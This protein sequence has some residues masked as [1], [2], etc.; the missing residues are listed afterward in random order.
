LRRRR[1]LRP[2]PR[3]PTRPPPWER[4]HRRNTPPEM[5]IAAAAAAE[6]RA[7]RFTPVPTRRRRRTLRPPPDSRRNPQPP[8]PSP[9]RRFPMLAP[10]AP[11]CIRGGRLTLL[12]SICSARP[13]HRRPST[14]PD[15][16]TP[17]PK[18]TAPP[19]R[20]LASAP[21]VYPSART[22]AVAAV[23]GRP[24]PAP[25]PLAPASRGRARDHPPTLLLLPS[26]DCSTP[27]K[28]PWPAPLDRRAPGEGQ[29]RRRPSHGGRPATGEAYAHA[30]GRSP[31][32]GERHHALHCLRLHRPC[33]SAAP[34]RVPREWLHAGIPGH[35]IWATRM[36]CTDRG[37]QEHEAG[38][39]DSCSDAGLRPG[40]MVR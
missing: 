5:H 15:E 25:A 37:H 18:S 1:S 29:N 9:R 38:K 4:T 17:P 36:L 31:R 39:V 16:R 24:R 19:N 7:R 27:P 28:L 6:H 20:P 2:P 12:S 30:S 22:A 23:P 3:D 13:S 11:T 8:P 34:V 35:Q 32:T 26:S 14:M 40:R 10:S 33:S 21:L